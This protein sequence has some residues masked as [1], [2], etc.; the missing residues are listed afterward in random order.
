MLRPNPSGSTA[1]NRSTPVKL[2]GPDSASFS[3]WFAGDAEHEAQDWFDTAGYDVSPGMRANVL[4]A[5]HHGSCNGVKSR[6]LDLVAPDWV[7]FSVG[8][9]N[10]Y[11]H[12]HTQTKELFTRYLTPWYRTDVNGTVTFTAPGTPGS[13]YTISGQKGTTSQNGAPDGT[14]ANSACSAL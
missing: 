1:N 10:S 11:G 9:T 5:N 14:S 3:M 2:V 7:T 6:Y 8:A 4:K 13:G 12:V